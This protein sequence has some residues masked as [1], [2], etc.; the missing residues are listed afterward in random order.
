MT[1]CTELKD[2]TPMIPKPNIGHFIYIVFWV[3]TPY[4]HVGVYKR[5]GGTYRFHPHVNL[6]SVKSMIK[7]CSC[8]NVITYL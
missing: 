4:D 6:T 1:K 3:V 8:D 7:V 5:F 2:A